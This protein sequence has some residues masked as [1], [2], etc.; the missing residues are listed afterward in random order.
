MFEYQIVKANPPIS[1]SDFVLRTDLENGE[2]SSIPMVETN[3]D[4]Q[5]YLAWVAEGNTAEEWNPE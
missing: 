3:L 4:Y 1:S 2:V 5:A